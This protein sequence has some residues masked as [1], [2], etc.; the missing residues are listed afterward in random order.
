[1]AFDY[2]AKIQALIANA[3]DASLSDA[4]RQLY[5]DKAESLMRQYRVAEEDA[6][7]TDPGSAKPIFK[8]IRVTTYNTLA[9]RD[10]E[11]YYTQVMRT[12][13]RHA[14]CLIKMEWD[15]GY[16]ATVC[17][18][19][20]DVRYA[21]YL[22]T[23]ALL[24]FVTRIDPTWD[25]TLTETENIWRLRNAGIERRVIADRAW[26]Y[27]AGKIASNRSKV[28]RIYVREC[29]VKGE[30][31]RA[32]G[33]GYQTDVY[34]EAYAESFAE[35]LSWRLQMARNAADRTGGGLVLHGRTER[36]QEALW[37]RFPSMR[38]EP[39]KAAP[40]G[41]EPVYTPC[42]KCASNKS[43][44]CKDHPYSA[45]TVASERRWRAREN[46][47]SAAAGRDSGRDAAA[48]VDVVRGASGTRTERVGY[49]TD[50]RPEIMG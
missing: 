32:A 19:E 10:L 20:G 50:N 23:S 25:D 35:E 7:A 39:A 26:G 29:T 38:P 12:I 33:L 8:N 49:D 31:V 27:G 42:P 13:V 22:W 48:R 14:G 36:V 41:A 44:K 5:R 17:G 21:E 37:D 46:S 9:S 2:A 43:G 11:R 47:S 1:M 40:E 16:V 6:L 28:Q 45:V 18:Y 24:M 15:A 3:D 4:A 34:R 30:P